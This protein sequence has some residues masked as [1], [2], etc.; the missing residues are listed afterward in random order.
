V[1]KKALVMAVALMA[2]AVLA[3]SLFGTVNAC[4]H[5][6]RCE[7]QTEK[8]PVNFGGPF[9]ASPPEVKECRNVK[10]G[11]GGILNYTGP[12]AIVNI[13][14][15]P[16]KLL[17]GGGESKATSL[18]TA[19]YVVNTNTGKG[20][21][22]YDVVITIPMIGA[23]PFPLTGTFEGRVILIGTFSFNG[24]YANLQE[25]SRYGVLRGTDGYE[26]WKLV[27]SGKTTGGVTTYENYMYKPV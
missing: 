18:W 11:R 12:F 1:N 24:P 26:G 15:P 9:T 8:I 19:N 25:G 10:I 6:G 5:R 3:T 17:V 13:T 16:P 7:K 14:A 22:C 20:V 2:I 23:Q 4:G 21:L 27:I